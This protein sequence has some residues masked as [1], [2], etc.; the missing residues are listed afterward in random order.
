MTE[1]FRL[2]SSHGEYVVIIWKINAFVCKTLYK[3]MTND[4]YCFISIHV[5]VKITIKN[6][7]AFLL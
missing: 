2:N 7:N 5:I 6:V 4:V 3:A 1:H